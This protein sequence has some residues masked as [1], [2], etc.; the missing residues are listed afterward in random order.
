[1]TFLPRLALP[2]F[3]GGGI[4]GRSD[5]L[6]RMLRSLPFFVF[7]AFV[8]VEVGPRHWAIINVLETDLSLLGL[9]LPMV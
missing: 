5:R 6:P 1:M 4:R 8:F 3:L 9:R 7:R 2:P